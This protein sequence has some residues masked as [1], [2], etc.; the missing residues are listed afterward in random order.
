MVVSKLKA[1]YVFIYLKSKLSLQNPDL[2]DIT[3]R[4][5]KACSTFHKLKKKSKSK[6]YSMGTKIRLYKGNVETVLLHGSECRRDVKIELREV[7]LFHHK[8]F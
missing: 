3:V 7:G 5:G 2:T 6:Q 4:P 8:C 1:V